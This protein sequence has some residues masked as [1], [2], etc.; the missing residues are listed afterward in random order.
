M[1]RLKP[2]VETSSQPK[3]EPTRQFYLR[4]GY[5]V[6]AVLKDFYAENDDKVVFVKRFG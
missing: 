1:R 5:T 6:E 2:R 3:Y 4:S